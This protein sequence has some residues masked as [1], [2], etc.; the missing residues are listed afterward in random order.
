MPKAEIKKKNYIG[1]FIT[2][3]DQQK[4]NHLCVNGVAIR[5]I[6][7]HFFFVNSLTSPCDKVI[8]YKRLHDKYK[9]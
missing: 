5:L 6:K 8:S 4:Q 2:S 3:M 9:K 7:I 1:R